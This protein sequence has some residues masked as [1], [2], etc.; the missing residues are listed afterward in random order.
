LLNGPDM[1]FANGWL[2]AAI[3]PQEEKLPAVL[4]G[5]LLPIREEATSRMPLRRA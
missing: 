5:E 2:E 3:R 1:D 4:G